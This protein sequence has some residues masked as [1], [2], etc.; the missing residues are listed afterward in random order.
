VSGCALKRL[1][2]HIFITWH[3]DIVYKIHQTNRIKKRGEAM[4]LTRVS[5]PTLFLSVLVLPVFGE[6]DYR[7][8]ESLKNAKSYMREVEGSTP[9]IL[10]A[11]GN[12]RMNGTAGL[13]PRVLQGHINMTTKIGQ[14]MKYI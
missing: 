2:A 11:A 4:F 6:L 14:R 3:E 12:I 10:E 5:I 1:P 7:Q 13:T 8:K 9:K